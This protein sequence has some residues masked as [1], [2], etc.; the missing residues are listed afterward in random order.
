MLG[1]HL[2]VLSAL[3]EA[4]VFVPSEMDAFKDAFVIAS[5]VFPLQGRQVRMWNCKGPWQFKS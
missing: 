2:M 1:F 3:Q 4:S 5:E